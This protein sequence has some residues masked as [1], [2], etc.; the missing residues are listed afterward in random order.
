MEQVQRSN[1]KFN[2][3]LLGMT[4]LLLVSIIYSITLGSAD[5]S[6]KEVYHILF[7][8]ITGQD[9]LLK[10][11]E[12][13][14]I[15]IVWLIRFPRILL[16]VL[17]GIA[18]SLSGAVMQAIVNNPL[19]DPY[20]LGISS[21]ASLGA[22]LA[23]LLGVGVS[24]GSNY[25]GISAFIGALVVS[26]LVLLFG[27]S[28]SRA[29]VSRLLLVGIALSSLCSAM[30]SIIVFAANNR[31]GMMT[32][33]FWLL[34]SLSAANWQIV[35]ILA[36]IVIVISLFF[37]F[38]SRILNL[39]LVGDEA[40]VTLG[41]ENHIYRIIYI[42]LAA[43]LIGFIVYACGIIGFVGLVVPHIARLLVGVNHKKMIPITI[44]FGGLFLLWADILSRMIIKGV[45]IPIGIIVSI[46][47]APF[48]LYLVVQNS[49][50]KRR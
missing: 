49:G 29:D 34:G 3:I 15:D 39:M 7:A 17:A 32:L 35:K 16:A 22:T 21:G 6:M 25:V 43:I 8:K 31:N 48:F 27:S 11:V 20:I 5:I 24:L 44:L 10:H 42:I 50:E 47:G 30:S 45:E 19:A 28:S 26:F 46:V 36:P 38:Q 23:I 13:G 33:N 2:M 14:A 1:W 18:L 40:A 12:K 41:Q 37:C 9:T 4:V